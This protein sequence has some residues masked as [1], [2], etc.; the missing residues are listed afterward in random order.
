[1]SVK[2]ENNHTDLEKKLLLCSINDVP[3][4][5]LNG[6]NTIGK[7]VDIY[8]GDTC[9]IILIYE[10]NLLLFNCR[11]KNVDTPEM[12][13]LKTKINRD[14]EIQNAIKCRNKLIQISTNCNIDLDDKLTKKELQ[15]ILLDNNKILKIKCYEFD[16]YGRLLVELFFNDKSINDILIEENFA[17]RYDGGKKEEFIY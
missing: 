11:L 8:D 3:E 14:V 16:K 12:K 4:F 9:K 6:I 2:L 13:P 17:K 15:S 1:M 10:N 7:I 5:S